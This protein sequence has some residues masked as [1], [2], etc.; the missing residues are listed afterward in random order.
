MAVENLVGTPRR[1]VKFISLVIAL[2][3][4]GA[5]VASIMYTQLWLALATAIISAWATLVFT[6]TLKAEF[7]E[8]VRAG[9]Q[10]PQN[11]TEA[12]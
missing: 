7:V 10:I 11:E 8:A 2:L 5:V 12:P 4:A 6:E 1:L 3:M 9:D